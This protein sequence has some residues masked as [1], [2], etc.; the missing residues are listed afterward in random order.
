MTGG[1]C[2]F[3]Y[4]KFLKNDLRKL[5]GN[6]YSFSMFYMQAKKLLREQKAFLF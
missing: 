6:E 4:L 1:I 3:S 5:L 2:S